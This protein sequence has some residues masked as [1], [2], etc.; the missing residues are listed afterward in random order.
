MMHGYMSV[1]IVKYFGGTLNDQYVITRVKW[2][3][4]IEALSRNFTVMFEEDNENS[5]LG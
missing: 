5:N 2:K 4:L 1:K 3:W